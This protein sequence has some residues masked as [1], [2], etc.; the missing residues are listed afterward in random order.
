[1]TN[2]RRDQLLKLRFNIKDY[3]LSSF[4]IHISLKMEGYNLNNTYLYFNVRCKQGYIYI[5]SKIVL[6]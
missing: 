5:N 4:A 6:H 2:E 3:M 1:M